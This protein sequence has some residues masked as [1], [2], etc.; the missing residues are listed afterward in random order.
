MNTDSFIVYI[1]T[2]DIYKDIAEDVETR[3]VVMSYQLWV[4]KTL[5]KKKNKNVIG[6]IKDK[7]GGKTIKEFF[8]LRA[9]TYSHLI[10]E[11]SEVKKQKTPKKCIKKILNL[12]NI[13]TV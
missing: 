9:K 7:L 6:L 1:K 13:K 4:G 8:A 10:D 11:S 3:Y 12:K 2:N 5:P